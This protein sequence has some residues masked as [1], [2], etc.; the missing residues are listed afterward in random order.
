MLFKRNTYFFSI[1][2]RHSTNIDKVINEKI[3]L[4]IEE[5]RLMGVLLVG[6]LVLM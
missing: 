5:K 4:D 3:Y 1:I 6:V 2:W